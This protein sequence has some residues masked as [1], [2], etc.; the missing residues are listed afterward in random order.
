MGVTVFI[1][2]SHC[3]IAYKNELEKHLSVLR[4][5]GE[6]IAWS[7]EEILPGDKWDLEINKN[8]KTAEIIL[9]LVSPDFL[10]SKYIKEIELSNV[11]DRNEKGECRVIPIILRKCHWESSLIGHLQAIPAIDGKIVPISKWPDK[12]EAYYTVAAGIERVLNKSDD[13]PPRDEHIQTPKNLNVP[14]KQV[15]PTAPSIINIGGT[16]R[17]VY[18]AANRSSVTQD[19]TL[20]QYES[21]GFL[22]TGV[23]FR[24][25][26]SGTITGN[27][28]S[29]R[30]TATYQNGWISQGNC[31]GVVSPDGSQMTLN[32]A[33]NVLGAF[34]S[35]SVRQ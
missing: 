5:N 26:G 2:Y 3:D 18:N 24:T 25:T 16:W 9:L 21:W 13:P 31:W 35:S 8:L 29:M 17:D 12:D 15:V 19:G 33:D 10:S 23:Q 6:V 14:P 4:D 7:D 30:Y 32:C 1:S 34:V 27:N 28:I 11:L 20:F 22:P